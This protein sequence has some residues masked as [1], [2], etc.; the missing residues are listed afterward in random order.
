MDNKAQPRQSL[1][2][3]AL[4][5]CG[6]AEAAVDIALLNGMPIDEDPYEWEQRH[7]A[8]R[9]PDISDTKTVEHY[10]LHQQPATS[11]ETEIGGINYMGIEIDFIVS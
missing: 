11:L 6:R 2:D 7:G 9:L 3:L 4:V 5:H 1:I 8:I 10:R